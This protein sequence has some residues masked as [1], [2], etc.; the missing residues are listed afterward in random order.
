MFRSVMRSGL[1]M[2]VFAGIVLGVGG[3]AEATQYRMVAVLTGAQE[4]PSNTSPA[5]GSGTFLVDT[6]ANTMTYFIAYSG[7][8]TAETAAHIHGVSDPGVNSGVLHGL[9]AGS[10]K[11][12]VWNYLE[13]QEADILAGRTYVNIHTTMFPGGEIRGQ[14]VDLVA[15]L[16][17][18]Q[19]VPPNATTGTGWGVFTI[20]RTAK[21]LSYHIAFSGV[22]TETAA[23]I[24]G[25][26]PHGINSGVVHNLP[27][28]SPKVGVWNYPPAMEDAILDGLT[29]VN[30][31]SAAFPGG[32]IRGQIVTNV[33]PLTGTQEVPP[34]ASTAAGVGLVS[35]DRGNLR[36]GYDLRQTGLSSAQTAAHIHG[37]S[38]PGVNSGILHNI[39]VGAQR[40]GNWAYTAVQEP[41]VLAGLTYFNSH[42]TMWPGGEIRGQI[43]FFSK[44]PVT[45]C[46]GDA[47]GNDMVDANDITYVILRLGNTPPAGTDGDV[48]GSGVVDANDIAFVVLRLGNTCP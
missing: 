37:F 15:S 3:A 20:D 16:D 21:T 27:A 48:D 36:L 28:G 38:A 45:P 30:V 34:N 47:D 32:E 19:E 42:T 6:V 43:T 40:V 7:L 33:V 31:H 13:S 39:G 8:T 2:S 25:Y 12:G 44:P 4:V 35:L 24:H 41:D 11:V 23:H 17:S 9:A 1:R 22:G 26:T 5:I 29:Y 46:E 18:A 10:P 14:I